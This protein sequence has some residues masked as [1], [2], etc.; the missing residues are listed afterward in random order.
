MYLLSLRFSDDQGVP[1]VFPPGARA[2][3]SS[4]PAPRR[5]WPALGVQRRASPYTAF[6]PS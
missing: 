1:D 2:P 5:A 4:I 3:I 6:Q